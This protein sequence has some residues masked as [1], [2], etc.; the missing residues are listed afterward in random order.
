M[1]YFATNDNCKLYFEEFGNGRPIIFIHGWDCNHHFFDK[2]VPALREHFRVINYDLRGHGASDR[3][4][5]GLTLDQFAEDLKQL[6]EYLMV[7]DAVLIG[8][9]MGVHII[10]EFIKKYG[11][12]LISKVVLI[13]MTAKMMAEED[14]NWPY[15]LFGKYDRADALDFLEQIANDWISVTKGFVPAMFANDE[16]FQS[17]IDWVLNNAAKNTIHVMVNMWL[18]IIQKDYRDMLDQVTVP[19]LV[20]YGT[21]PS[22]YSPENSIWLQDHLPHGKAIGFCGGHIH[23]RQDVDKFNQ[24]L[25]K[26][27]QE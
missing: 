2:Q 9:S 16:A 27:I 26:F 19:A 7:E 25:I 10:F 12:D 11:C 20:T 17:D 24:E 5:T 3:P 22:L 21:E 6:M 23:F 4:E 1:P 18:A 8:W 14:E 15:T 13:D